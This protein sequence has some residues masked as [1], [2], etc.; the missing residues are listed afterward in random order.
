MYDQPINF[1]GK[2][3]VNY[4]NFAFGKDADIMQV[5]DKYSYNR[6]WFNY[7]NQ[8]FKEIYSD[9]LEELLKNYLIFGENRER[10]N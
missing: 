6:N 4:K 2:Y 9:K 5:T 10:R 3:M 7:Y 8:L 1:F